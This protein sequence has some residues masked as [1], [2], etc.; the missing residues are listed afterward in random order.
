VFHV[1]PSPIDPLRD[2]STA[3]GLYP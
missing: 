2:R 1:K 3:G